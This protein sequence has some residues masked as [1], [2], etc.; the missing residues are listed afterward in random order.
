MEEREMT[1]D[2][3]MG[4]D[5]HAKLIQQDTDRLISE[6]AAMLN[7]PETTHSISYQASTT[8]QTTPW[9]LLSEAIIRQA[10]ADATMNVN[11]KGCA[12]I[13]S[14][15]A[16]RNAV[17][18]FRDRLYTLHSAIAGIPDETMEAMRSKILEAEL[19]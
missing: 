7:V 4:V 3:T 17:D 9:A 6:L 18:Y 11:R 12:N 16:K 14:K 19:V 13:Y 8:R 5:S 2:K 1:T 10:L 15:P